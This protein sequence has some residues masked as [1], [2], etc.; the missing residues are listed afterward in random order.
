MKLILFSEDSKLIKVVMEQQEFDPCVCSTAQEV[1][2]NISEDEFSLV[3]LDFDR[4]A[5]EADED[6]DDIG[7]RKLNESLICYDMAERVI[8]SSSMST[9]GFIKHQKSL[10]AADGYLAKPITKKVIESI[11]NDFEFAIERDD[12]ATSTQSATDVPDVSEMT[13]VGALDLD[14]VA[15]SEAKVS[16][17]KEKEA[18]LNAYLLDEDEPSKPKASKPKASKPKSSKEKVSESNVT[19]DKEQEDDFLAYLDDETDE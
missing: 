18:D 16:E 17:D 10:H 3:M 19:I 6:D 13:F 9:K 8:V 5:T 11:I 2:E 1:K 7:V 4:E 15:E 14:E 12:M